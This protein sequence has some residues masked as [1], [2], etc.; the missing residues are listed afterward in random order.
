MNKKHYGLV[1]ALMVA[2]ATMG[3]MIPSA[4][5]AA[6]ATAKVSPTISTGNSEKN[7]FRSFG[8]NLAAA[9]YR[10]GDF[11]KKFLMP[12][13]IPSTGSIDNFNNV[14]N[15]VADLGLGQAD[16]FMQWRSENPNESNKVRIVGVIPNVKEC[17]FAVVSTTAP[18][19]IKNLTDLKKGTSLNVGEMGS[20]SVASWKYIHRFLP[21][22][23]PSLIN[24]ET[25]TSALGAVQSNTTDAMIFVS[26]VDRV[27]EIR[28][29]VYGNSDSG[30]KF[31]NIDDDRLS[32]KLPNGK[33]VYEFQE[34]DLESG[35]MGDD[36]TVPCTTLLV[37]GAATGKNAINDAATRA[38]FNEGDAI[39]EIRE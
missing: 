8:P 4:V 14:A 30:V 16:A 33:R 13:V 19:P 37:I 7:Y 11:N 21:D 39:S 38:I 5:Q 22:V 36:V 12:T 17:V 26:A 23:A 29:M 10:A 20:G 25:D 9:M 35:L 28:N 2:V 24:Y 27:G 1:G 3:A 34:V 6:D 15:G 32:E 31:I 18:N